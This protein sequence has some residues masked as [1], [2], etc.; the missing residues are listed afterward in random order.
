MT[1]EAA[2]RLDAIEVRLAELSERVE[3][4][5]D[6]VLTLTIIKVGHPEFPYWEWKL[7][8][9]LSEDQQVRLDLLLMIYTTRLE[10]DVVP[11]YLERKAK[12]L[13][14]RDQLDRLLTDGA[15]TL[16]EV[17]PAL[18]DVL[19]VGA[20]EE[21]VSVLLEALRGQGQYEHLID[22]LHEDGAGT[23]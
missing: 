3:T 13:F 7:T 20:N 2:S 18:L 21:A 11:D 22:H 9:N 10:G 23:R 12:Q 6:K 17:K 1:D 4:L 8:H 16:A 5:H 15:P 19:G 14:P